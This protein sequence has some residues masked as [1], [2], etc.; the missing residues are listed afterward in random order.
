MRPH[1]L[2][3]KSRFM[4]FVLG[5]VLSLT[6]ALGW[7]AYDQSREVLLQARKDQI[8]QRAK[9]NAAE[10][11]SRLV[12]LSSTALDLGAGLAVIRPDDE[13]L[14]VNLIRAHL[15]QSDNIYGM[16]AAYLPYLFTPRQRLFSAYVYR[17]QGSLKA[18][19]LNAF[20]YNY[21]LRDWFLIPTQT[22]KPMWTEPYFDE[23]AGN[24]LMTTFTAPFSYN[25]K[26]V[27]VTTADIELSRLREEVKNLARELGGQAFVL[28]RHGAMLAG[29]R[30]DW[31][32]R[33]TIFSLAEEY[34]RA[35]IRSIGLKMIHG[36]SGVIRVK[37]WLGGQTSWLAYHPVEGPGWAFGVVIPEAKAL[38][39]VTSLAKRQAALA[40]I[41]FLALLAVIWLLVTNLTK[42]MT[43][44]AGAARRLAEGDLQAQVEDIRP[45][46]EIGDL[47][48]AFN[49]MVTDLNHYISELTSATAAKE[50]IES[51]LD[52]A[53]KIQQSILPQTYPAFPESPQFDAYGRTTPARQVGG[54][55]YDYFFL[56]D[57]HL[58]LVIADVSGK[59][60]PAALFMTVSRT[61][62]KNSAS[63]YLEPEKV[64]AEVNDQ[65]AAENEMMMF[66]TV[67]YAVYRISTGEMAFANAGHA[68]PLRRRADG[69]VDELPKTSG[70][71][72]GVMDGVEFA[73]GRI[74]LDFGDT[75]VFYTDG[76]DEAINAREEMY[77][78]GRAEAWLAGDGLDQMTT[79]EMVDD[80]TADWRG[81]TGPVEQFD[82]LTLLLFRR[83][84]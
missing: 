13:G 39:P 75:L 4:V 8:F 15:Q 57:D 82:D 27:G 61:L 24:V 84:L 25:G 72:A 55:F 26:V 58:G 17:C 30:D 35:D 60:V 28:S 47:A 77:G 64:L 51:E 45:G 40:V 71:A 12:Q 46:D 66:V 16:A 80:L 54:D 37:N 76:L 44:L 38:A 18:M 23:G 59:G 33:E 53:R 11:S 65:I 2:G 70:M 3:L 10:L 63:H 79:L 22:G 14:V 69:T 1:V 21:P 34:G 31:I 67:F 32:M 50:R 68:P 73:P 43:R 6:L 9:A 83:L 56:D 29:R 78:K 81:F 5:G 19:S 62:I 48:E 41:G 52:L 7:L 36:E 49:T 74:D 42:P 20:S